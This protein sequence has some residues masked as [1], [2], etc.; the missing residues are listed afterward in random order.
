VKCCVMV[1]DG[2]EL[3]LVSARGTLEPLLTYALA[4]PGFDAQ[5]RELARR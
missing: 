5:V 4:Q 2:K 1:F 3:V